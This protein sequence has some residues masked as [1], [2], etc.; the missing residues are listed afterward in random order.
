MTNFSNT[1]ITIADMSV[2]NYK[3]LTRVGY[4]SHE[5]IIFYSDK[6]SSSHHF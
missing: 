6:V 5:V 3:L 1:C 2:I 4:V